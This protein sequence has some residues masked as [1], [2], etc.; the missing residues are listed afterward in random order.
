M[1]LVL[2]RERFH[3]TGMTQALRYPGDKLTLLINQE[4]T[5]KMRQRRRISKVEM[6]KKV[7]SVCNFAQQLMSHLLSKITLVLMINW[8]S[9]SKMIKEIILTEIQNSHHRGGS[10]W[11][12][13]MSLL[14]DLIMTRASYSKKSH[15]LMQLRRSITMVL[16]EVS[17]LINMTLG[18]M[19]T[20][21][22]PHSLREITKIVLL[23]HNQHL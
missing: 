11:T 22:L 7:A 13:L 19:Q 16:V 4:E 20:K 9:F 1:L 2:A 6:L 17:S 14:R 21:R 5:C 12:R 10:Y 3:L 18:T 15:T 8:T 23:H